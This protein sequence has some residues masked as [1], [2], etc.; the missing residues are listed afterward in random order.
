[1]VTVATGGTTGESVP[2]VFKVNAEH[3]Y[4]KKREGI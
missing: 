2:V 1:M 4:S 3:V